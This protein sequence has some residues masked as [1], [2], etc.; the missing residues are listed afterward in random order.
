MAH[1][2]DSDIEV[3]QCQIP[4][5]V[6][7]WVRDP[8]EP[9]GYRQQK[10]S[11]QTRAKLRISTE[12]RIF[13]QEQIPEE[14]RHLDPFTNGTLA[15]VVDGKPEG[16]TD[17]K[18]KALLELDEPAFRAKVEAID[19]ELTARRLDAIAK[20]HGK[21]WQYEVTHEH[22]IANWRAGGTQ[23]TVEEM[24]AETEGS[25]TLLYG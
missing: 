11:G 17:D 13:N 4:G 18:L 21:V 9:T 6:W 7:V 14:N 1:D 23:A 25:G 2:S 12:D 10:V 5:S 8:R 20:E 16:L 24:L 3:W 22:V 19:S 15:K